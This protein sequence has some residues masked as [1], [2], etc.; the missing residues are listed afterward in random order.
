[1]KVN[2]AA[3]LIASV[4]GIAAMMIPST[5]HALAGVAARD[6]G[7]PL[8]GLFTNAVVEARRTTVRAFGALGNSR[9]SVTAA[10]PTI[11]P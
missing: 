8:R 4:P 6:P 7:N 1:M 9:D 5:S 2:A 3:I 11:L 10:S